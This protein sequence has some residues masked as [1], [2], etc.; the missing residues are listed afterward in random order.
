MNRNNNTNSNNNGWY[1]RG[2]APRQQLSPDPS[3]SQLSYYIYGKPKHVARK[4][5]HMPTV[6]SHTNIAE[7]A[8]FIS[9]IIDHMDDG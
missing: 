9:M 2:Q 3:S 6:V 4:C 7:E 1:P 8:Q 5:R